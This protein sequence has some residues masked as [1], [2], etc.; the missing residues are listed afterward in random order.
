MGNQEKQF[1]LIFGTR[2]EIIKFVPVI[3]ELQKNT[4]WKNPFGDGKTAETIVD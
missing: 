3:R 4:N 1:A 2:P